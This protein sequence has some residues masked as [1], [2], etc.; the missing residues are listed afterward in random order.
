MVDWGFALQIAGIG[1]L[2]VFVVLGT[3]SLVLW[4]VSLLVPKSV[5]LIGKFMF[6]KLLLVSGVN[7][8]L[9]K[10]ASESFMDI[11]TILLGISCWSIDAG[12]TIS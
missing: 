9:A 1:F 3:L 11:L 8:R 2:T 5:P 4:L 6:G 10:T 12:S 7:D